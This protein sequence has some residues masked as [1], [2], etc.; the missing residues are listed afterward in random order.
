MIGQDGWNRDSVSLSEVG[1]VDEDGP[2]EG[3]RC[4]VETEC[5]ERKSERHLNCR[6]NVTP[7]VDI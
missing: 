5:D 6:C 4:S 1:V 7:S 3:E 2:D